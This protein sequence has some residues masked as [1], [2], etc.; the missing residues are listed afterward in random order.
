[1]KRILFCLLLLSG[2][3]SAQTVSYAN[4]VDVQTACLKVMADIRIAD[5]W[6]LLN[7]DGQ[8][9]LNTYLSYVEG[10]KDAELK[11]FLADEAKIAA[12]DTKQ[13]AQ[14]NHLDQIGGALGTTQAQMNQATANFLDAFPCVIIGLKVVTIGTAKPYVQFNTP[15]N[16]CTAQAAWSGQTGLRSTPRI[17]F[18]GTIIGV[19][20]PTPKGAFTFTVPD[21]APIHGTYQVF[22]YD[23]G[24]VKQPVRQI[25]Y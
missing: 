16:T 6:G 25:E 4:A 9:C 2:I 13:Q 5:N 19:Y 15:T 17:A 10:G 8:G 21:S 1:V 20:D 18:N 11:R 22:T 14:G 7:N 23:S 3:S 24:G 12:L